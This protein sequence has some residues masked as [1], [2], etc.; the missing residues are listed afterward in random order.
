M[1]PNFWRILEA[2]TAD[3]GW[4]GRSL[5]EAWLST[6]GHCDHANGGAG[7]EIVLLPGLEH[8]A[9]QH[10]EGG[11]GLEVGRAAD[12]RCHDDSGENLGL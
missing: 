7:L 2:L 9:E 3:G 12:G 11:D 8:E 10:D 5:N 6:I 1:F 4:A